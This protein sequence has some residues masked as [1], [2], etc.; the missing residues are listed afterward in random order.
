MTISQE[1]RGNMHI[2]GEHKCEIGRRNVNIIIILAI[3]IFMESF[4]TPEERSLDYIIRWIFGY[5][6]FNSRNL[7]FSSLIRFLFPQI[8]I[9]L[10]WGD[11]IHENIVT[12]YELIFTR[13]RK[14]HKV[15]WK[16]IAQLA[17]KST[18]T[19]AFLET[20]LC[21]IYLLKGCRIDS[22]F[23]IC[24]DMGLYCIYMDFLIIAVNII[25]LALSSIS[26]VI[27]V[28]VIQ[29]LLLEKTYHILQG[30]VI[31]K[32][33]Y[34]LPTS[35]V[36][37]VNNAGLGHGIKSIWA[38]YLVAIAVVLFIAGCQYTSHREYY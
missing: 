16:Y 36:M 1:E 3:I 15:L 2:K 18:L 22:V 27:I 7:F 8:A 9:L 35:P 28:L 12:N 38:V 4:I 11:Y 23:D 34:I 17:L 26:S 24:F 30:D 13:T 6:G 20:V 19:V 5:I 37:L 32:I 10:L 21:F 31:S 33:Y 29:L 14:S 25:S